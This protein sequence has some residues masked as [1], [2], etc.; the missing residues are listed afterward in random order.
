MNQVLRFNEGTQEIVKMNKFGLLI[1]CLLI[2]AVLNR[3][4]IESKAINFVHK[5]KKTGRTI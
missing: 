5:L 3:I 2:R 1:P 4:V